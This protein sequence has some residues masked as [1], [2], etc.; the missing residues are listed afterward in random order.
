MFNNFILWPSPFYF[1]AAIIMN[2]SKLT[3][4]I[5]V[6]AA[7]WSGAGAAGWT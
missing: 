1:W 3:D 4:K 7:R 5:F 2:E 6:F